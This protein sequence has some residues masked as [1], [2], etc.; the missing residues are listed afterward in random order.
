[1]SF[2]KSFIF[3]ASTD[4]Y[5]DARWVVMVNKVLTVKKDNNFNITF[6][7]SFRNGTNL[8]IGYEDVSEEYMIEYTHKVIKDR[9]ELLELWERIHTEPI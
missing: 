3:K 2:G 1:M 7:V 5:F 4:Q 6:H 8:N 9:K